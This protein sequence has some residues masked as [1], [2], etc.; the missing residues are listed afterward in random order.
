[1]RHMQDIRIAVWH[2]ATEAETR[3]QKVK[4]LKNISIWT[5]LASREHVAPIF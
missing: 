5:E 4:Q 3:L 2:E 1:M